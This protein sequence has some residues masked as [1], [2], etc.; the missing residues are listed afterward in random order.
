MDCIHV[1]HQESRILDLW[2]TRLV[3]DRGRKFP[4]TPLVALL[5][6]PLV[7]LIGTA[8][9][10]APRSLQIPHS[11]AARNPSRKR[12]DTKG[13]RMVGWSRRFTTCLLHLDA[14]LLCPLCSLINTP[15]ATEPLRH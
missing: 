2:G 8:A 9:D 14:L 7:A 1:H 5:W 15:P 10:Q 3:A 13:L 12:T 11:Q 6:G 4:G